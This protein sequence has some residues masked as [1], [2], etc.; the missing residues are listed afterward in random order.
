M[1]KR[2]FFVGLLTGLGHI[3]TLFSLKFIARHIPAENIGF[4]GEIDSLTL[5]LVS[6]IA[7]GLQ[8]SSTRNIAT[9]DNWEAELRVTQSARFTL[10]LLLS[11]FAITGLM[12]TKNYLFVLAPVIAL[13]SDYALYGRGKPVL[14]GVVA[15]SR[16]MIPAITLILASLFFKEAIILLFSFSL[17]VTYLAAG[18]LSSAFLKTAYW[19][20]PK[21]QNLRLYISNFSIGIASFALFFVG[22]GVI[23][24]LSYFYNNETI[25]VAYIALKFYMIYKGVRRILVQAFFNQLLD[26]AISLKVDFIAMVSGVLFLISMVFYPKVLIELLFDASYTVYSDT[27]LILGMAGF[28]A[29]ITTSAGTRL[30][31]ENQDAEYS[32]NLII[33]AS[34]TIVTGVLLWG[35]LGNEP[36]YIAFSV[37]LGELVIS[38][39]NT[40]S[41]GDSK[42]ISQRA[43][44]IIYPVVLATIF[45]ICKVLL[46]ETVLALGISIF[47]FGSIHLIIFQRKINF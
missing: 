34:V 4:I 35:F 28:I 3:T 1:V 37:L 6:V 9:Q 11:L 38:I 29:S 41:L 30:L 13:N 14:G 26:K 2:I 44:L 12:F 5:L 10:G 25:A 33:A 39:L 20:A 42:F 27:F 46:G 45:L 19:V 15:L 32:R 23:N 16:V 8:L 43:R 36:E 18:I 7:F 31:L 21:W 47:I 17:L 22:I 24:V 40:K